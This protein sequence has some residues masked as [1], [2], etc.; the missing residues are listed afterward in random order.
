MS[1][2]ALDCVWRS[3]LVFLAVL[4][5]RF[6][7]DLSKL[8][9]VVVVVVFRLVFALFYIKRENKILAQIW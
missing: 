9:I 7:L 6:V 8:P 4:V 3:V 5:S 2:I 1:C